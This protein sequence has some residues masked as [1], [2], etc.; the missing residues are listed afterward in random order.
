MRIAPKSAD[1]GYY[2]DNY[3]KNGESGVKDTIDNPANGVLSEMLDYF[4]P[5]TSWDNETID[6]V[7]DNN[8]PETGD[9]SSAVMT[10]VAFALSLAGLLTASFAD[11]KMIDKIR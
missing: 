1:Y 7:T 6:N 8:S 2:V 5:W 10:F 4:T 9:T 11:K 3:K